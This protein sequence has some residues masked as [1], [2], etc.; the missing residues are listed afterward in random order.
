MQSTSIVS[1]NSI[2]DNETQDNFILPLASDND[3]VPSSEQGLPVLSI[4]SSPHQ[5]P[6]QTSGSIKHHHD[7]ISQYKILTTAMDLRKA[8]RAA[9]RSAKRAAERDEILMK[10]RPHTAY[11]EHFERFMDTLSPTE[12]EQYKVQLETVTTQFRL[13]RSS[14]ASE[15]NV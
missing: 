11:F 7:L 8:K 9:E 2:L 12:V 15:Q 5:Q 4:S 1:E 3:P 13:S 10:M 6:A 14:E